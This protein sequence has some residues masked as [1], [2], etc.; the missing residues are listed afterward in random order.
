MAGMTAIR[1]GGLVAALLFALGSDVLPAGL[2][3]A[4]PTAQD[5][6]R[7]RLGVLGATVDAGF[8]IALD[9]GYFREQGLDVDMTPF[10]SAARMVAPL[11]AGQLDAG[12]GAHS[13]GLF[14]A[15]ARGIEIK[16]VADKG[17]SPPGYGPQA[18]LFRRDL[19]DSGQL[20][21]PGDLRGLR[22][23]ISA[24][25]AT[26][27][28]SLARWL[29]PYGLTIDD[30]DTVELGFGE[31]AS[32]LAGRSIEAA[33]ALE[34]FITRIL[35]EGIATIYQ[36]NDELDPGAQLAEVIYGGQFMREQPEAARRFM[37]AYVRALRYYNDAFMGGDT[38]K[39]QAAVAALIRHT[40]V[41]DPAL[42]DRM[43]MPGL[44][45]NGRMHVA[46]IR[47]D[48][49]FWLSRGLQQTRLNVDDVVDHSYVDA[50]VQT[51]GPY[52]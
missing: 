50:A 26:T 42:Y 10:D 37:V 4:A 8:Y 2:A 28:T 27:E 21:S 46:S 22:V 6:L 23:A 47:E 17:S 11:G 31:H 48:Q 3:A 49:E 52:R 35:D 24:H 20:R 34:P 16:L 14:N 41:K 51:L 1:L 36:R 18:L 9:Q 7:V 39:R 45:P 40:A 25:G 29:R 19:V 5:T 43:V 12:G 38:A 15:V 32:A 13:A 30:V 44:D 33:V